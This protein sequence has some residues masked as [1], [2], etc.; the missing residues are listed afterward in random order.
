MRKSRADLG[1]FFLF[2]TGIAPR[3]IVNLQF[4]KAVASPVFLGPNSNG[5]SYSA[6]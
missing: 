1:S 4:A 3:K 6:D 5:N 2:F